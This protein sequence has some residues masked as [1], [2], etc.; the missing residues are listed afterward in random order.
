MEKRT[1]QEP[2]LRGVGSRMF[3]ETE[4]HLHHH[5]LL[6]GQQDIGRKA[7]RGSSRETASELL[8][9]FITSVR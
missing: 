1:W 7:T 6:T 4:R 9:G 5:G 8:V 3:S 2:R